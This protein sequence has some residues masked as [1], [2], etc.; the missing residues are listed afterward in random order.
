M[1]NK[2]KI[3]KNI[4]FIGLPG[5]G[6]TSIGKLV[7]ERLLLPFY[8]VDA[9]IEKKEG[10]LIREIFLQGEDYF[11]TLESQAIKEISELCPSVISTGGGSVKI[12]SNMEILQKNSTIFYINRPI[13]NIIQDIDISSRPLLAEGIQKL[14][15]LYEE[16]Y[17][18]YKKY[19]DMEVLNDATFQ[20]VVA[21]IVELI[22]G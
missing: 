22:K 10:R 18:L 13:E 20:E 19:S 5:S 17:P 3:N 1:N 2:T 14:Y 16:R 4:V 9:Y 15:R 7:S 8:D 6:K 12:P 21:N 11:R